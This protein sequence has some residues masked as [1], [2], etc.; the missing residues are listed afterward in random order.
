MYLLE[1]AGTDDAFAAYEAASAA[2]RVTVRG[3]GVAI[4]RGIT[5]RVS[6]LALTH[7]VNEL[8]GTAAPDLASARA[9]VEAASIDRSGSVAVRARDVRGATGVSTQAVERALGSILVE[10]GFTVDLDDPNHE[11]R[12]VF[13]GPPST[14]EWDGDAIEIAPDAGEDGLCA[15]GWLAVEPERD[16]TD[17]APTDRPFFQPGSMDPA[18]ARALVNVAGARPGARVLDPM[19]GTGGLLLEATRVGSAVVGVDALEKMVQGTRE[20]LVAAG[21]DEFLVCRGDA[22]RLPFEADTFDAVV[23]DAPYGRQTK[24]S[25]DSLAVLLEDALGQARR[26]APR[27]VVVGDRPWADVAR[28]AG[29]SVSAQFQRRVHRSLDR[30]IHVLDRG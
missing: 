24:V 25:A 4:A 13:A 15:L 22:R 8:L 14:S 3:G 5:D 18:L 19:C 27:A 7:R 6:Q 9:L 11:L 12:A 10:R 23:V 2:S 1:L 16:F 28:E 30:F 29:W 20:N 17:R 26:V 21:A